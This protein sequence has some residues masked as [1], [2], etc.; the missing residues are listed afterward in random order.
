MRRQGFQ[1]P[2]KDGGA[3]QLKVEP[4]AVT[5]GSKDLYVGDILT[6]LSGPVELDEKLEMLDFE[7]KKKKDFDY[8]I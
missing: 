8:V 3:Y 5:R 1:P 6:V 4:F 2:A 7:N